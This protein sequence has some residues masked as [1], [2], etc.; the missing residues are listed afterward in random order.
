MPRSRSV[1]VIIGI[2]LVM[3]GIVGFLPVVGF[4]MI[5]LGFIVLSYEFAAVRRLRRRFVVWF[6]RRQKSD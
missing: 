5:P 3:F 2:L 1:R 6:Q 4:W